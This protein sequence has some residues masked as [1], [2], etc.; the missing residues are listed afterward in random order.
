MLSVH[1]IRIFI[2]VIASVYIGTLLALLAYGIISPLIGGPYSIVKD[3][4]SSFVSV[5]VWSGS[6]LMI[7]SFIDNKTKKVHH[8][9]HKR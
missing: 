7:G 1:N 2:I 8:H 6:S 5:I 9:A 4:F 3:Y